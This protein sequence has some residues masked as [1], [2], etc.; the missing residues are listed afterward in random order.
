ME[1]L[2]KRVIYLVKNQDSNL[3]IEGEV[4]LDASNRVISFS[5]S[6]YK[7]DGETV[8]SFYYSE[9]EQGLISK[10]VGSY[11]PSL[12]NQGI[13]LLDATVEALKQQLTV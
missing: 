2:D 8:G 1:L 9:D 12:D 13:S 4:Q 5:G 11:P 10:S 6:F 3:K 7:L